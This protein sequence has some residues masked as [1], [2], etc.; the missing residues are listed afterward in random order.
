MGVLA[1]LKKSEATVPELKEQVTAAEAEHERAQTALAAAKDAFDADGSDKSLKF[2]HAATEAAS[3]SQ[4][5]LD[6]AKRLLIQGEARDAE[7][8]RRVLL[9]RL[10][11]AKRD[12]ED[13]LARE[14]PLIERE[15]DLLRQLLAV[16]EERCTVLREAEAFKLPMDRAYYNAHKAICPDTYSFTPSA[17]PVRHLLNKDRK[18]TKRSNWGPEYNDNLDLVMPI[19]R[20]YNLKNW[21]AAE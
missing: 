17:G 16:R 12:L 14:Q 13:A 6:R 8:Q 1:W 7:E 5:H 21:E 11:T 10:A 3:H 4:L 18:D 9:E 20:E 15:A 19:D 2:L